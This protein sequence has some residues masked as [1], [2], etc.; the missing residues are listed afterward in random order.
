[1]SNLENQTEY[2]PNLEYRAAIVYAKH[3]LRRHD[4]QGARRWAQIA[5]S[6]APQKEE[7]WLILAGISSPQASINYLN[8]ALVINPN[9][10]RARQGM[11]WAIERLRDAPA[12]P[13]IRPIPHRSIIETTIPSQEFIRP[14]P[15]LLPWVIGL[16][17]LLLGV[18]IWL[19]FPVINQIIANNNPLALAQ[20]NLAKETR[21]PTPTSTFTPTPTSTAT[22]TPTPTST[23]TQTPTPTET[24][25]QTPTNT[26]E[27]TKK[28]KKNN[29]SSGQYNYPGRPA[30]VGPNEYWVDVD[31]SQQRTYA[32]RGDELLQ[33]FLVSTGT[34]RT[35]T[36]TG[37]FKVYVKY[38]FADMSGPGYYLPNVPFVMY[39]YKGYGLHG[40]YWHKNFGTP[41]S[42]GCINLKKSEAEW[43]FNFA[44]VGTIVNIHN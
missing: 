12:T 34:W 24:P 44:S 10:Q 7:A 35:P 27:P 43:L 22:F 19:G 41:M 38:R 14:Q 17:I 39:F 25:T 18:S 29:A 36:V 28:P 11:H 3:A 16:L 15:A 26:P 9:S 31:L 20:S 32:Y 42:H 2:N 33:S 8:T 5:A 37:K 30:G 13:G 6:L 21:T 4:R 23:Y 1:M 40:T